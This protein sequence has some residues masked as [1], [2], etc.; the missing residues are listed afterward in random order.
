[1]T[2]R[3][4]F[5]LALLAAAG[6]SAQSP[7]VPSPAP[8]P[9]PVQRLEVVARSPHDPAAFTQGLLWHDGAF[10]ESTGR[11]GQSEI[12]R[13]AP[14]DGRV[15]AR[16]RIPAGQF[17][18]GMAL[19]KTTLVSLTWKNGIAHRWDAKSLQPR[20]D[21]R[22]PGEGWGL[23][24]APEGLVLS[25]GTS[26]L[27]ILDPET[28]A[29]KRRVSVTINGR[30]LAMLNELEFVDGEVLANV[31]MTGFIVAIDPAS[32]RV[33]R[34]LDARAIVAEVGADDPDAVLN[35]I[36][37]DAGARRLFVTG[38]LWPTM[39]EVKTMAGA[40]VR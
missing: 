27:R 12:R 26:A 16:T 22:Y 29:E 32:G 30:P 23:T 4:L 31:W 28:L 34:V 10:Y 3:A 8:A 14:A 17:G 21:G 37:W 35:G 25:D 18:E 6:A 40:G 36:A 38:K 24:T 13:V 39:F 2:Y 1:M 19:W 15:V 20:G 9:V 11:E 33:T 5:A 7:V